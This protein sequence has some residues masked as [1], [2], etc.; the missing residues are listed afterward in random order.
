MIRVY[1]Q[2]KGVF[3][4]FLDVG[5]IHLKFTGSTCEEAVLKMQYE[6]NNYIALFKQIR[7]QFF[8]KEITLEEATLIQEKKNA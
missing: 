6:L 2:E 4:S 8:Y 1:E 5:E 7:N 3:I